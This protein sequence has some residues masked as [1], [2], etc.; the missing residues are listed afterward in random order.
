[1]S[2]ARAQVETFTATFRS[3]ETGDEVIY[4][5]VYTSVSNARLTNI[6]GYVELTYAPGDIIYVNHLSYDSLTIRPSDYRDKSNNVFYLQPRT[7]QLKGINFS[8][9]GNRTYFDHKFVKNDL[10]KS[11][12]EKVS[13]K[14]NIVGMKKELKGL[15]Q[16][17]QS[18]VVLGSPITYLY[19]RYSKAGKDKA[20][21]AMLVEQDRLASIA[22]KQFDDLTVTTLTNYSNEELVRFKEFCA[23]HPTYI[24]QVDALQLY[25]E[26]LRCR[27]EFIEKKIM[28]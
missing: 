28:D 17:A 20:R 12:E 27:D 19:D 8:V 10:G 24:Q 18:G 1:V 16:S 13:E 9:L 11:D 6:D 23:F 5:K 15:D 3:L 7:Y 26:I 25:F 21:Y 22:R 14:L 2:S 4:A